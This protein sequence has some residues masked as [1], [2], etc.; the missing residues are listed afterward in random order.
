MTKIFYSLRICLVSLIILFSGCHHGDK[1]QKAK[2]DK[3]PAFDSLIISPGDPVVITGVVLNRQV[4]PGVSEIILEIPDFKG[5]E[6]NYISQIDSIGFFKFKIYPVI[7][8]EIS[9]K[10]ISDLLIVHPGDSMYIEK[11]FKNISEAKFSG[12]GAELNNNLTK[13]LSSFYLGRYNTSQFNLSPEKYKQYC[14]NLRDDAYSRLSAFC[15][16]NKTTSEF[17]KWSKTTIEIDYY[18]ALLHYLMYRMPLSQSKIDIPDN[19][20]DF[21]ENLNQ[22]FDNSV[23]CSNYFKLIDNYYNDYLVPSIIKKYN[24]SKKRDHKRDSLFIEEISNFSKNNLINQFA[25]SH[26]FNQ[27]LNVHN[28]EI[29]EE[30]VGFIYSKVKDPFLLITLTERYR[31]I[32]DFNTNPKKLSNSMLGESD[33]KNESKNFVFDNIVRKDLVNK[34]IKE[35]SGKVIY[36]DFWSPGCPPCIPE[37][38]I[39]NILIQKYSN[40]DI[41]F[42]FICLSGSEL[43]KQKVKELNIGGKHFFCNGTES[44]YF[45]NKYGFQSI[46]HYVLIDKSGTIVDFGSSLRPSNPGTI[47]KIDKLLK[48]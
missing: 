23:I 32:K 1:F 5:F 3:Y 42:V 43:S 9:L 25:V 47:E 40:Q 20:Y 12:D 27:L 15:D 14:E 19:Y 36:I 38:Q 35:N 24:G 29:F 17:L 44:L 4:Y 39:S 33:V 10:P 22:K 16:E 2:N 37:L 21:L 41:E 8:R 7:T 46:P 13:F 34:I 45:Q 28:T 26:H 31:Y 11:D 18:S 6:N 30:N 48:K